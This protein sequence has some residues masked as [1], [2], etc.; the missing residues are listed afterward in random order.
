MWGRKSRTLLTI[1]GI[2]LGV[3]VVLA[4][5]IT[6]E[7]TLASIR[8]IFDEASGRAHLVVNSNSVMGDPFDG[9]ALIRVSKAPGVLQAAPAD[10]WGLTFSVAGASSANDLLIFGVDPALDRV[11][12]D[13]EVVAGGLL[14][15]DANAYVALLVQ[16]YAHDKGLTVGD[17]LTILIS[18]RAES[19][20]IVG[21]IRKAGPGMQNNG[22]V[23]IVPIDAAQAIFDLGSDLSQIDVLV[24]PDIAQSPRRLDELKSQL[25][26]T[27]GQDYQVLYPAARGAVVSKMLASYQL[28]LSFFSAVAL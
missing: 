17:D 15:D 3:A 7:S 8:R 4:I 6:N 13:Y 18:D 20:R 24:D 16:D 26:E 11:V 23:A 14:P 10:E 12:R 5:A 2:V 22:A 21:L 25:T 28:G 1:I 9:S 19:F 27:L